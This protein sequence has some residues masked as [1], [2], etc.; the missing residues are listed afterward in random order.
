MMSRIVSFA[1][2]AITV[3]NLHTHI[4]GA[5]QASALSRTV[6]SSQVGSNA[7]AMAGLVLYLQ[8]IIGVS[9]HCSKAH[10]DFFQFYTFIK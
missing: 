5:S 2:G 3:A 1:C 9:S 6:R 4:V 7:S 8:T 10:S